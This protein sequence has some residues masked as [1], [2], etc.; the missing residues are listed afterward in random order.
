M[1]KLSLALIL[2]FVCSVESFSVAN[3]YTIDL[4]RAFS[5]DLFDANGVPYLSPM[6]ETVNATS[7]ARFFNQ[8]YIPTK[9]DKP[10]FK[11]GIHMMTGFVD[12]SKKSYHP[13]LPN[14]KF[15]INVITSGKYGTVD[16]INQKVNIKDTAGLISYLFKNILY[17][18]LQQNKFNIPNEASTILGGDTTQLHL[19]NQAIQDLVKQHPIY[20]F[21]PKAL[22]DTLLNAL[23]DVPGFYT[24]PAGGNMS[25]IFA[26]VPQ[27]EIGSF[28]GT[29]ALIRFIPEVD[30]GKYIGK[31]SFWGIGLKHSI[32]QYF[33]EEQTAVEN[34]EKPWE[35]SNPAPFDLSVQAAYQR[36]NLKNKVGVTN[37]NLE[38]HANILNFNINA[39][40]SIPD[41]FDIYAG[42]SYDIINIEA[43][44]TYY[45]PV[46][47]QSHLGLLRRELIDPNNPNGGYKILGPEP[48]EYPG[49]TEPQTTTV[50][51]EDKSLKFAFGISKQI[52]P[53]AVFIDYGF[54]KFNI[55][56][57][58][59]EYRF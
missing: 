54:S 29:E 30:L 5:K 33:Y 2:I 25:T 6:V 18:G 58:G 12:N 50:S 10:Y 34:P 4:A 37:S 52:G 55:L 27:L 36:T 32:S 8:A 41:W 43:D 7:N 40:K 44:F 39:S 56:S 15:D 42:L 31:F 9:V 51:L 53:I 22:Q 21:L 45:L 35:R 59:I 23:K 57:G 1:K 49:D 28:F 17:D 11:F 24:L 3:Q 47:T 13:T 26:G 16:I 46:E 14:E 38:A 19:D 48:P 20:G